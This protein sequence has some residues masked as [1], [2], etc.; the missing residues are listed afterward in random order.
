MLLRSLRT[1]GAQRFLPGRLGHAVEPALVELVAVVLVDELLARHA[2]VVGEPHQPALQLHQ[3][4]VDAVELLDQHLDAGVVERQALHVLDDLVAQLRVGALLLRADLLGGHVHLDAPVLQLAELAVGVGDVV[5]GLQHLGLE[6]G[7]HGRQ[8]H[9]VL[10]VLLLLDLALGTRRAVRGLLVVGGGRRWRRRR[11]DC[12][13]RHRGRRRLGLG[14]LVGRLQ[15]DHVA[16]Q[17]LGAV[18]L[19]A[20]DDDGLEGERAL[21]QA[22]DHGLAAGLDALGDGDLAFARQQLNGAH[23]A[24]IHANGIV[25]AVGRLGTGADRRRQARGHQRAGAVVGV[26]VLGGVLVDGALLGLL[27]LDHRDA[28][29]GQ[30]RQGVLDLVGR[31]LLRGQHRIQLV[32][33]HEAARLGGLDQPLDRRI[34]QV[35]QRCV[36]LVHVALRRGLLF[37]SGY[38]CHQVT[39]R[40]AGA[41]LST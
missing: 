37:G 32:E 29:V 28:H 34:G 9:G 13:R 39:L 10:E 22:G 18:E 27:A 11:A 17:D 26:V 33:R 1:N 30:H 36:L 38:I 25:R 35:E 41:A 31:E 24:Q 16:Q 3:V 6:L 40:S 14:T 23:V 19:V 2:V 4:A 12:G 8:R 21:A 20:P 7:L 15:I 5:E